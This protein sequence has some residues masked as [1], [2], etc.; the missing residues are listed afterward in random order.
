MLTPGTADSGGG[1]APFPTLPRY[2]APIGQ[3]DDTL[4]GTITQHGDPQA[5]IAAAGKAYWRPWAWPRKLLNTRFA[6]G[7]CADA[8]CG[9]FLSDGAGLEIAAILWQDDGVVEGNRADN[10]IRVGCKQGQVN[11]A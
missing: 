7:P 5:G 3:P 6:L 9:L 8:C 2:A 4:R 1:S 10:M 11:H